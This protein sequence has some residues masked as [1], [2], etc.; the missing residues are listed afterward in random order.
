MSVALKPPRGMG[1]VRAGGRGG[2]FAVLDIGTS[3]I[4]CLIARPRPGRGCQVLGRGYQLADGLERGEIIDVEAAESSIRAVL[5]EAEQQAGEQVTAVLAAV[6]AGRPRSHLMRVERPLNGRSITDEDIETALGRARAEVLGTGAA[7]LHVVPVEMSVDG[8]RPL[9][10]PRG[11]KGQLLDLLVHVVAADAQP[12]R[13]ITSCLERAHL[14]VLGLVAAPYAAGHGCLTED[15]LEQGC[16]LV[17]MG[18]GATQVAHFTGGNLAFV[19]QV[20]KGGEKITA[21]VA[22]GLS[23]SLREAERLKT[24]YGG[25]LWRTCDDNIRLEVP[26]ID[27]ADDE[28][29]GE[30]SRTRLT[31]IIRS[32]VEEIFSELIER[33]RNGSDVLRARPPRS[34]VLTG[35]A[36]QL[37][38]MGELA[39]EM[40]SLKVRVARPR[41]LQEVPGA[42]DDPSWAVAAGALAMASGGDSGLGW[43]D[44]EEKRTLRSGLARLKEWLR[45]NF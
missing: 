16:L 10:D 5:H 45:E 42:E 4:C 33:L 32:R 1:G 23:S 28:P 13:T 17:D 29:S 44:G 6:G 24:L 41:G 2:P 37:E 27:D 38:G 20:L 14:D 31:F 7:V 25:V 15:E 43:S 40:F 9:R 39:E 30:V 8:G 36:A 18:A 11:V 21:D 26:L 35:G 34:I 22:Y 3:K 12:L 19:E